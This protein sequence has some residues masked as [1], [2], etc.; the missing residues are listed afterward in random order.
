MY[1][2]SQDFVDNHSLAA[3]ALALADR[4]EEAAKSYRR[5]VATPGYSAEWQMT[6]LDYPPETMARFEEG[7]RLAQNEALSAN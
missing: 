2:R 4:L 1:L 6:V 3:A 5:A 7:R